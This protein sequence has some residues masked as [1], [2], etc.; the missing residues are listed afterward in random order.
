MLEA[1]GVRCALLGLAGMSNTSI[2]M[3]HG[4][5]PIGV[6][7]VDAGYPTLNDRDAGNPGKGERV[8]TWR[9]TLPESFVM[10]NVVEDI[11]VI[12][13]NGEVLVTEPLAIPIHK[14]VGK[15]MLIYVNEYIR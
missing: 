14:E 9:A 4:R 1:A 6:W 13:G 3:R 15:R 8:V 11:Q 7:P 12:G 10:G 5:A 2:V